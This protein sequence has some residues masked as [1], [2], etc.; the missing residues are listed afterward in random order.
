M[1]GIVGLK[2][3]LGLLSATGVVP[4]CRTLDTISVFAV[5][6]ADAAEATAVAQGYDAADFLSRTLPAA[7]IAPMPPKFV[8][9]VPKPDQRA[10]F[11]DAKSQKAYEADLVSLAALGATV[12]EIDFEPFSRRRPPALRGPM[13]GRALSRNPRHHR[14]SCRRF[15]IRSRARSSAARP[16]LPPST[17][18]TRPTGSPSMRRQ[19]AADPRRT[20]LPRRAD[21]SRASTPSRRSRPT[22]SRSTP[23]SAPIPIS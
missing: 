1:N 13:G 23:T 16:G 21:G 20:R 12:R 18:S 19:V 6:V 7:G 14:G 9:G 15:C 10:F 3:S 5:T 4:A 22:R 11:G 8:V 2:P 17:P